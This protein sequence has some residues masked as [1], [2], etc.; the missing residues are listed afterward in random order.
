MIGLHFD[1]KSFNKT[2]Q[3]AVQYG[4]GF[5]TGFE[6]GGIIVSSKIASV[7]ETMLGKYIDT[8]ARANPGSLHHVYE[9]GSVGGDRLFN[10]HAQPDS[11]G[12]TVTSE[13]TQSSSVSDTATEPFYNKAEIMEAGTPITIDPAPGSVLV[14]MDGGEEVFVSRSVTVNDP[15]GPGVQGSFE[16]TF[17]EFFRLYLS[18]AL[19]RGIGFTEILQNPPFD[20][21]GGYGAGQGDARR[22]LMSLPGG[23]IE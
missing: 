12:V 1:M 23:S 13:F 8:K 19:L 11:S 10:I 6:D 18:Q 2:M 3:Q 20:F 17:H 4:N 22:W 21:G 5:M 9:W 16:R 7:V 15:G 14:F